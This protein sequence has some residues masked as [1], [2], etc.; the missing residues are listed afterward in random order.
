MIED[1][2]ILP[3]DSMSKEDFMINIALRN[4]EDSLR[5]D[6]CAEHDCFYEPVMK[7]RR[8]QLG[9]EVMRLKFAYAHKFDDAYEMRLVGCLT[10]E[11]MKTSHYQIDDALRK[12]FGSLVTTDSESGGFFTNC[13]R[14]SLEAVQTF[15]AEK[16]PHLD[17]NVYDCMD[18]EVKLNQHPKDRLPHPIIFPPTIPGL[19]LRSAEILKKHG[20]EAP[21][22]DY[23]LPEA[24][25]KATKAL[26][27]AAKII[28]ACGVDREAAVARFQNML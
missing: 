1:V 7:A 24:N 17:Y 8:L 2:M 16:Y 3:V 21:V 25:E 23:V 22:V 27:E 10:D 28:K 12:E 9:K 13:T 26:E 11:D 19:S 18:D 5:Y 4:V 6:I 14:N 15:L 20:I